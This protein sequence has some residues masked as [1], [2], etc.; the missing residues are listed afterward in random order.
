MP[1][2]KTFYLKITIITLSLALASTQTICDNCVDV[3][4]NNFTCNNVGCNGFMLTPNQ[5]NSLNFNTINCLNGA[6]CYYSSQTPIGST[7]YVVYLFCNYTFPGCMSCS[8]GANCNQCQNGYFYNVYNP[9]LELVYCQL[10]ED[11]I[12]GCE[13]CV[14]SASCYQC[15]PQY[16]NIFGFCYTQ[17]GTIVGATSKPWNKYGS[18]PTQIITAIQII[19][20]CLILF[21]VLYKFCC[22]KLPQAQENQGF[23][24]VKPELQ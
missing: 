15:S 5:N 12:G 14:T 9:T 1:L 20:I 3:N 8:N 11:F 17:S 23:D 2:T 10:C 18:T 13:S 6:P 4:S 22:A 19:I 7:S 24:P 16:L 21:F